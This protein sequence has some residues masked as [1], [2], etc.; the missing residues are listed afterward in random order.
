MQ[1]AMDVQL[2]L[3]RDLAKVIVR[4]DDK[5]CLGAA[6]AQRACWLTVAACG[7]YLPV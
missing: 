2:T 3:Y 1:R 5:A 6:V 7:T 4:V